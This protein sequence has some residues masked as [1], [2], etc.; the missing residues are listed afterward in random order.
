MQYITLLSEVSKTKF[1]LIQHQF[2]LLR[3]IFKINFKS[4]ILF[5]TESQTETFMYNS[6]FFIISV[7]VMHFAFLVIFCWISSFLETAFCEDTLKKQEI[8]NK[9]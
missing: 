2:K 7:S 4:I 9:N 3:L 5:K 8:N 1:Y 6:A